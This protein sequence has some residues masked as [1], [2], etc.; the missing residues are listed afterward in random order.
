M[1]E[2]IIYWMSK[3]AHLDIM[4]YNEREKIILRRNYLRVSNETKRPK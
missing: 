2:F 3:L 1:K 4:M